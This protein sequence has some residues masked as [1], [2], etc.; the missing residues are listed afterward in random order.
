MYCKVNHFYTSKLYLSMPL[1]FPLKKRYVQCRLGILPIRS[2]LGRFDRQRTP[3]DDRLCLYCTLQ[4]C[5]DIVHFC[6]ICPYNIEERHIMCSQMD[7]NRFLQMTDIEII[8][9]LLNDPILVKIVS[10]FI[11]KSLEKRSSVGKL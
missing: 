8:C 1:S 2:H 11:C 5:D 4:K 9:I 7:T 3:E 10:T 6:L